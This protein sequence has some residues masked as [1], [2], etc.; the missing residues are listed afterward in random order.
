M[1]I[2]LSG[3]TVAY[4][5][6]HP[7]VDGV[8]ISVATNEW[9]G[10]L[11]PNG[12]GKSS[13]LRAV[14]GL[15][16][17]RGTIALDGSSLA[18][19]SRRNVARLVAFVPQEPVMPAGMS[20]TDYVLLGRTPYLPYLGREGAQDVA[21]ATIAMDL[22]DLRQLV[23]RELKDL[24]GGERQRVALARALAQ[25][26]SILLLDEP[27]AALDI[28]HQQ[29]ALQ[30]I[31]AI[32]EQRPMTIVSA[33]HDLTLAGQFA[34]RLVLLAEGRVVAEGDARTVLTEDNIQKYY[35]ATVEI[36]EMSDG[37]VVVP[38]RR[39]T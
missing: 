7:V 25:Q 15:V 9:L 19:L 38:A 27:T 39:P 8:S 20:V 3:L 21:A 31:G 18:D 23:A 11:G 5:P 1:S 36:I 24:S 2:T 28:G 4:E 33:M 12:A 22:L 34:D 13:L 10:L 6:D 14:I 32:R 29:S 16:E 26:P 35:K 17:S 30:M 37:I